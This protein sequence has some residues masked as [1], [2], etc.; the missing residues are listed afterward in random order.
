MCSSVQIC[1]TNVCCCSQPAREGNRKRSKEKQASAFSLLGSRAVCGAVC[2][3]IAFVLHAQFATTTPLPTE[4]PPSF[5]DVLIATE[6]A[7]WVDEFWQ[8]KPFYSAEALKRVSF[9]SKLAFGTNDV[10]EMASKARPLRGGKDMSIAKNGKR[11]YEGK[12]LKMDELKQAV[13]EGSSLVFGNKI[14]MRN[15]KLALLARYAPVVCVFVTDKKSNRKNSLY[16]LDNAT[17]WW[18][19]KLA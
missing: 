11:Q 17:V 8:K 7:H 19:L 18:R 12:S 4:H 10:Q 9:L 16:L 13:A 15:K 5:A 1:V 6:S 3:L 2:A 14:T